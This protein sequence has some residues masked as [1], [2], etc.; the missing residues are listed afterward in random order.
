MKYA[1]R[2]KVSL[3]DYKRRVLNVEDDGVWL[4]NGRQYPHILPAHMKDLNLLP[5]WRE[6]ILKYLATNPG[7]KLHK[8]FHHLNSSQAMAFN[9]LYP[10]LSTPAG[11]AA[12]SD[13]LHLGAPLHESAW[14]FEKVF[15]SSEG[16]N[17]DFYAELK[18]GRRLLGE[19]KLT[20]SEFGEAKGDARHLEKFATVYRPRLMDRLAPPLLEPAQFFKSYQLCRNLYGLRDGG[21]RLV[22]LYPKGN[23]KVD[24]QARAFVESLTPIFQP[25]IQL[26]YLTDLVDGLLARSDSLTAEMARQLHAFKE[27]Y[28][29]SLEDDERKSASIAS[30]D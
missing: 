10:L 27:K 17:F 18:D 20:E 4:K 13:E 30:T 21:D 11:R 2:L 12:L 16:T 1:E 5:P 8:D 24:Q 29:P 15:E 7:V 3:V 28:C 23:R 25:C 14:G 6:A 9:L 19:V 22:F 26:V